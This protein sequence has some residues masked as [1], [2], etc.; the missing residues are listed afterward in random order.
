MPGRLANDS[1]F[2][3][4]FPFLRLV[5][6]APGSQEPVRRS[7]C[8]AKQKALAASRQTMNRVYS[9]FAALDEAGKTKLLQMLNAKQVRIIYSPDGVKTHRLTLVRASQPVKT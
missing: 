4:E 6:S 2:V 9:G 3:S 1:R 5:A 7:C 8:K